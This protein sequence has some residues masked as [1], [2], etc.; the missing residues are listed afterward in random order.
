MGEHE[1]P[2]EKE[3]KEYFVGPPGMEERVA[4]APG[5]GE[6]DTEKRDQVKI[7]ERLKAHE[8]ADRILEDCGDNV[9]RKRLVQ[10]FEN[11]SDHIREAKPETVSESSLILGKR[12]D[13]MFFIPP[14]ESDKFESD[15][16]RAGLELDVQ[17]DQGIVVKDRDGAT[18]SFFYNAEMIGDT[19][20]EPAAEPDEAASEE[21]N[22]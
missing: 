8:A 3:M 5:K 14:Q 13:Q 4:D 18:F 20:R 10:A 16:L 11:M 15:L 6:D 12:S 2:G 17:S 7:S 22:P 1:G 21:N 19:G 9:D